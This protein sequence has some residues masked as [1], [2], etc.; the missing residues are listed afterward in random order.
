MVIKNYLIIYRI[1]GNVVI[2]HGGIDGRRNIRETEGIECGRRNVEGRNIGQ[3][4]L[5]AEIGPPWPQ[6]RRA[7]ALESAT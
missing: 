6:A 5:N 2:I 7:Y 4:D 1:I 3:R